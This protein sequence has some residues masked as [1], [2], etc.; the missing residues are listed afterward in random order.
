MCN[1]RGSIIV[2]RPDDSDNMAAL[3]G[4]D[5]LV[6]HR[7]EHVERFAR[8]LTRDVRALTDYLAGDCT[9]S[10]SKTR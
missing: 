7:Q 6:W 9:L 5:Y 8:R 4:Q 3:A 1:T 10:L 2:K